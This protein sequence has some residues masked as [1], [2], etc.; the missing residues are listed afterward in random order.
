MLEVEGLEIVGRRRPFQHD[1]FVQALL[2]RPTR[3]SVIVALVVQL[4]E[5]CKKIKPVAND[6]R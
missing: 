3:F 2:V 6:V 4:L 1:K 5:A